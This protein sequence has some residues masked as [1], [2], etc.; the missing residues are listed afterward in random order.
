MN[1]FLETAL[2]AAQRA[3]EIALK[4]FQGGVAVEIKSDQSPVTIADKESE[5]IIIETVCKRHPDHAFLGEETGHSATSSD[6]VW[7]IDPIDGTKNFI[8][9]IPLFGTQ[10]ALLHKRD[11]IAGVSS[12]PA[13]HELLYA[14][15]G[16][17]FLNGRQVR[18]SDV[19]EISKAALSFAG[20]NRLPGH[21]KPERM[22]KLF[23]SVDRVR[24]FG[25]CYPFHL[26]A[27]GRLEAVVQ[28]SIHIWDIA[29]LVRIIESAGGKCTDFSG[30][31]IGIESVNLL[32][33]NGKI[34]DELLNYLDPIVATK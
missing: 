23:N 15:T 11:L 4:Y 29:A 22:F 7:I 9:Q 17:A 26:L 28:S 34:H 14:D 20:L 32:A 25:D 16:P 21:I 6:Y 24:G 2:L 8:R 31:A 30:G 18:V 5:R 10:I 13:M 3:D 33:T 1:E 12:M 19:S 27:S